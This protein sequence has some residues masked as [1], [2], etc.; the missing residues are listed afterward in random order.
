MM[1]VR[2]KIGVCCEGQQLA[3]YTQLIV[4]CC[5]RVGL[6]WGVHTCHFPGDAAS[7]QHANQTDPDFCMPEA[8]MQHLGS[9]KYCTH[10]RAFRHQGLSLSIQSRRACHMVPDPCSHACPQQSVFLLRYRQPL[11]C[12]PTQRVTHTMLP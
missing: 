1:P 5:Q 2:A 10:M 8:A 4:A 6:G 9:C 3:C 7:C 11:P 12:Q